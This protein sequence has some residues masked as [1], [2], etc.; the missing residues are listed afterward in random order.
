MDQ[1]PV[2]FLDR[3]DQVDSDVALLAV[4][5]FA[6]GIESGYLQN[7]YFHCHITT[8]QA[9]VDHRTGGAVGASIDDVERFALH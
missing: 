4:G 5:V 7:L 3:H 2:S 8:G 9:P 1:K 6:E